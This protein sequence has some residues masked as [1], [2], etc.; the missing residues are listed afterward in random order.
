MR[1]VLLFGLL[2]LLASVPALAAKR[3]FTLVNESGYTIDYM[4]V[5]PVDS[6]EWSEDILGQDNLTSGSYVDVTW[7][8][9]RVPSVFDVHI[10]YE[11]GE[12]AEIKGL[13]PPANVTKLHI[14]WDQKTIPQWE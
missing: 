14:Y 2:W 4:Y 13:S 6:E 11:D 9:K 5:R 3:W 10:K 12:T 7:R 8:G 1:K